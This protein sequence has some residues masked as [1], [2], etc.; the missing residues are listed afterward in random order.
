MICHRGQLLDVDHR[1]CAGPDG[2]EACRRCLGFE[3]SAPPLAYAAA[4][5]WSAI[6]RRIPPGARNLV[7]AQ[8]RSLTRKQALARHATAEQR[9][10][11][12]R[13]DHMRRMMAHVTEFFAPSRFLR[14]R[15][16]E[17]GVPEDR[18]VHWPNGCELQAPDVTGTARRPGQSEQP[19]RA[20]FIG[21][22]MVSKAPHLAIEAVTA[23]G[24]AASLELF[25][26]LT[27]YHGER[28]YLDHLAPLLKAEGIRHRGSIEHARIPAAL[29]AMDVLLVPSVWPE[30]SP[31]VIQE[32]FA[33]GVPVIASRI[34]GIPELVEHNRN[35][36]LF[37]SGNLTDL[38]ESLRSVTREPAMLDRLRSGIDPQRTILD[39]V[40][41]ARRRYA[42]RVRRPV[43]RD[44]GPQRPR[45]A[46]VVLNYRTPDET[47]LA[48]GMLAAARR[49]LDRIFVV[50][51]D[52][53]DSVLRHTIAAVPGG[54]VTYHETG[55]NLGF[56][57]G[58]NA[59]IRLALEQGAD[60]VLL[61][62]SDVIVPPDCAGRLARALLDPSRRWGIVAPVIAGRSA[63]LVTA[64]RGM[65]Y[66][67]ATGRMRHAGV[68][69]PVDPHA[70][71]DDVSRV[72][73][74]DGVSACAMLISRQVFDAVGL[75]DE[76]YFF[77]FE[78][79]DFC[80]RARRAGF[81]TG[82]VLNA[83]AYHEGGRSIGPASP[84]RLYF[85][86]RNHL[87][88][89]QRMGRDSGARRLIRSSA[90]VALNLAHALS[91]P[92]GTLPARLAAVA[93]G[94]RDYVAG[95]F[96]PPWRSA[97]TATPSGSSRDKRARNS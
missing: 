82:L 97:E 80:L 6:G 54:P 16:I 34:G 59:G 85:A 74:V 65:R 72:E 69:L 60:A 58:V 81:D 66:N 22:L 40:A 25:G 38:R 20:G 79:L 7:D 67:V 90:V 19:L 62:N 46:A 3:A 50:D 70:V 18:I 29:A 17:F 10:L 94:T 42:E 84:E 41:C 8:L 21:S 86:A 36:L 2:A 27:P 89:A 37:E 55:R 5:A 77:S 96:G 43:T 11:R 31:L 91:A 95:R 49:P 12:Q 73:R 64:S 45:L 88:L 1:I 35:G 30:N 23:L 39:D 57:G 47:L 78:D 93:R 13:A 15:F 26:A 76:D 48:V 9:P 63:P 83:T 32:A 92:G 68:G 33:A 75:F 44:A 52:V 24:G 53:S 56:S 14:E 61:V 87:L 4:R 71:E 51:N 28:T